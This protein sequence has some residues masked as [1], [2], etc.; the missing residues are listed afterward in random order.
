VGFAE[1]HRRK[2]LALRWSD[3]PIAEPLGIYLGPNQWFDVHSQPLDTALDELVRELLRIH[4]LTGAEPAAPR[5]AVEPDDTRSASKLPARAV[6]VRVLTVMVAI[7]GSLVGSWANQGSLIFGGTY[8]VLAAIALAMAPAA[9]SFGLATAAAGI[10]FGCISEKLGVRLIAS[11][12]DIE[13]NTVLYHCFMIVAL[14]QGFRVLRRSL[15]ARQADASHTPPAP[16]PS[17]Q[18]DAAPRSWQRLYRRCISLAAA[19]LAIGGISFVQLDSWRY[20]RMAVARVHVMR[21]ERMERAGNL[22][23]A[24]ADYSTAAS[25]TADGAPGGDRLAGIAH[26][27][28]ARLAARRGDFRRAATEYSRATLDLPNEAELYFQQAQALR[29]LGDPRGALECIKRA[30]TLDPLRQDY[31]DLLRALASSAA[32]SDGARRPKP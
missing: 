22:R 26:A 29:G 16:A 3:A 32:G 30:L 13:V 20:H 9:R 8:A 18:L 25:L 27:G 11:T 6:R 24:L 15:V 12:S 7:L 21:A 5:L 31:R 17:T 10:G 4:R 23:Q 19:A 28:C 2:L 14:F 1:K